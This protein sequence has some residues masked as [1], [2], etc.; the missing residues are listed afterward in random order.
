MSDDDE[1]PFEVENAEGALRFGLVDRSIQADASLSDPAVR[2]YGLLATYT[3]RATGDAYPSRARLLAELGWSWRKLRRARE[4]LSAAGVVSYRLD[5]SGAKDRTIYHLHHLGV[6][7]ARGG[8]RAPRSEMDGGRTRSVGGASLVEEGGR[9]RPPEQTNEQTK[10]Q[11]TADA[12][13]TAGEPPSLT[14]LPPPSEDRSHPAGRSRNEAA[15]EGFESFWK[16]YPRRVGKG[17]AEKAW[18]RARRAGVT[19]ETLIATAERF[20]ADTKRDGTESRFVPHPATWLNRR[21]W[22]D[23]EEEPATSLRE[24]VEPGYE[25]TGVVKMAKAVAADDGEDWHMVY[26]RMMTGDRW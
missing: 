12:P 25:N 24:P 18:V 22:E 10:E 15:M 2:L 23:E 5:Q 13:A 20:A 14:L 8:A 9:G 19:V 6:P 26:E 16:A 1:T 3:N 4:E 17:A 21:P 7:R 11:T